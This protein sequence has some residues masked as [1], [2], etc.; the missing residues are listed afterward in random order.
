MHT[1]YDDG[2][3]GDYDDNYE[4]VEE[5][6]EVEAGNDDDDARASKPYFFLDRH[7]IST[8]I[9]IAS[10]KYSKYVVGGWLHL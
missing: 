1:L 7:A 9:F 6:E 3:D 5:E 2:D 4:E 10:Y 8:A